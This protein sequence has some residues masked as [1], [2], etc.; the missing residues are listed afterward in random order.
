MSDEQQLVIACREALPE[1]YEVLPI[2]VIQTL[3]TAGHAAYGPAITAYGESEDRVGNAAQAAANVLARYHERRRQRSISHWKPS[4]TRPGQI[5]IEAIE[6]LKVAFSVA[7]LAPPAAIL[8]Q[9][10]QLRRFEE[11]VSD[12][13]FMVKK[14][15]AD[16]ISSVAGVRIAEVHGR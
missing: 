1:G 10:D 16:G 4:I 13:A 3:V 15:V 7:S 12:G 2:E 8:L 5:L 9:H 14:E 6:R 11:T